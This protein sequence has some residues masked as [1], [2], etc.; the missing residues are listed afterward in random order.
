M[1]EGLAAGILEHQHGATTFAHELQWG[2][3]PC[4]VQFILQAILV[5]GRGDQGLWGPGARRRAARQH[6]LRFAVSAPAAP[7]ADHALAILPQDLEAAI[8]HQR[9][10]ERTGFAR[11]QATPRRIGANFVSR[12]RLPKFS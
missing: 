1:V 5:L 6:T 2:H 11:L 10:S 8:L 4:T 7:P 3:G 9:P 12:I